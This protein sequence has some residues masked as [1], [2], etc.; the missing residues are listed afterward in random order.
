MWVTFAR[1]MSGLQAYPAAFMSDMIE[2]ETGK[3]IEVL[4]IAAGSGL[5]GIRLAEKYENIN[6]TAVDWP[7]VLQVAN[8][9]AEAA[10]VSDRHKLLP[11]S[12]FE[13]DFGQ[14]YDLILLP[15]FLHHFDKET[16]VSFFRKLKASLQDDGKIYTL[17]FVPDEDRLSPPFAAMFSMQMLRQTEAGD[18]YTVSDL[19]DMSKQAELKIDAVVPIPGTP[20]TVVVASHA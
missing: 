19:T 6:V 5:F 18:A 8:E 7:N 2:I 12:A 1:A 13:V 11:G 9:N 17:E 15:N 4:D 3:T 16:C 14:K 10:G 20:S